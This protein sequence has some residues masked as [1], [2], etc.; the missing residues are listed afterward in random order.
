M[1]LADKRT[2]EKAIAALNNTQFKGRQITLALAVDRRYYTPETPKEDA[3]SQEQPDGEEHSQEDSKSPSGSESDSEE[4]NPTLDKKARKKIMKDKKLSRKEKRQLI[5]GAP[6]DAPASQEQA[7]EAKP[8]N[9][10]KSTVFVS[11]LNFELKNEDFVS[12]AKK[13]GKIVYAVVSSADMQKQG[14]SRH[15]QRHRIHS[16]PDPGGLRRNP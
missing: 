16:F 12:H 4:E 9:D 2:A 3:K 10:L 11:N 8:N 15:K 14:E 6:K 7:Q 13:L 1:Q 5:F